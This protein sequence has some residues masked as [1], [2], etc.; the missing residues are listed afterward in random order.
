M[1]WNVASARYE[2]SLRKMVWWYCAVAHC[3]EG[4][5]IAIKCALLAA[6]PVF[7]SRLFTHSINHGWANLFNEQSFA[8]NQKHQRA[9]KTVCSVC[10]NT[11]KMLVLHE[12]MYSNCHY[13][14]FVWFC[15]HRK[16]GQYVV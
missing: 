8:E 1:F 10:T 14:V 13:Y 15:S 2:I 9:P 7:H 12:I 11:I 3:L 5:L 4:A 6:M 16:P